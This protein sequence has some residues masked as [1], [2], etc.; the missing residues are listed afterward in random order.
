MDS[1]LENL[2]P[3]LRDLVAEVAR[4]F[5]YASGFV[6]RSSE[7]RVMS[8]LR[9]ERVSETGPTAGAVFTVWNGSHFEESATGDLSPDGLATAARELASTA[10][11]HIT[12]AGRAAID[13]PAL[14][15]FAHHGSLTY[16]TPV[17]V[18]PTIVSL[19]EKLDLCRRTRDRAARLD[20]R[21]VDAQGSYDE[22]H[23]QTLFAG[24]AADMAQ[25][26]WRIGFGFFDVAAEGDIVRFDGAS[27]G[28]T[29]GFELAALEEREWE[30]VSGRIPGL[31]KA[32]PI[33]PGYYDVV[34][35]PE[36]AGLI[37]HEAFGH[38]V[39]TDMFLKD[40]A[41]SREYLGKAV[42]SERVDLFDDPTYPGGY[43]TY[44][45][46]DEGQPASRTQILR[47]GIFIQGLTD[48]NAAIHLGIPRTSNGRR[49]DVNKVYPRM[50]NTYFA[51]GA[52]RLEDMVAGID[53]GFYLGG[54]GSGMEDPKDWGIQCVI[55][56]AREIEGGK[57]T[58]N[59]HTNVGL[60]GYVP[61]LLKSVSM[62]GPDLRLFG[63]HCGKGHKEFIRVGM[64]GPYL[65]MK[66]RLG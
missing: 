40:R 65:K 51:P 31:L 26:I 30:A 46:D 14:T 29:G 4:K 1:S 48:L 63:G 50:T 13:V 32:T 7:L 3:I 49:Q 8:S 16:S 28:G 57:L 64:G 56:W 18:D 38:G 9:D 6:T 22:G 43:G 17:R 62:V 42:G 2:R 36:N 47:N 39:E 52:D 21:V 54:F 34:V 20:P 15:A 35:D 44:G 5:P 37:A 55:G 25:E 33:K 24:P 61:D 27:N 41:R 12:A 58:D 45:F 59:Y 53:H 19:E 10:K 11:V 66:A 23:V 60:T